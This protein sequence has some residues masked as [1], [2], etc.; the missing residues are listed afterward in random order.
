[1]LMKQ[2]AVSGRAL[3]ESVGVSRPNEQMYIDKNTA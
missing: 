2:A 3:V 1:M